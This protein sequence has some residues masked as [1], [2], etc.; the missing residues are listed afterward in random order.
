[1]DRG[2]GGPQSRSEKIVKRKIN[3]FADSRSQIKFDL[4]TSK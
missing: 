3:P 1:M 2:L 4:R